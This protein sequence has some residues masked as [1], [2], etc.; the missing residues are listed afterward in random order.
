ME[1]P[2]KIEAAAVTVQPVSPPSASCSIP[3]E[4]LQSD[5]IMKK[6]KEISDGYGLPTEGLVSQFESEFNDP[7]ATL[8]TPTEEHDGFYYNC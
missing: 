4:C 7:W 2:L 5:P 8:G 3:R 6:A 1:T